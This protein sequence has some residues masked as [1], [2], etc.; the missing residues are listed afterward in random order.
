M[1][2]IVC[3]FLYFLWFFGFVLLCFFH[4]TGYSSSWKEVWAE[5]Q[6]RN[7]DHKPGRSTTYCFGLSV[8]LS[9]LSYI[10]HDCLPRCGTANSGLSP[11]I[12]VVNQDNFHRHA[13]RPI[14]WAKFVSL[15]SSE[16]NLRCI[17][18]KKISLHPEWYF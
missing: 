14:W 11:L 8:L 15:F 18:N 3:L 9:L 10:V 1:L 16:S 13:H 6:S 4:F 5:T 17:D 2:S 12:I 7:L